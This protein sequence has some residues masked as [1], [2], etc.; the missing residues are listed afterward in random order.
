MI[1]DPRFIALYALTNICL[2]SYIG[3][4]T[5]MLLVIAVIAR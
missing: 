5:A 3:L 2:I 4:S 1:V